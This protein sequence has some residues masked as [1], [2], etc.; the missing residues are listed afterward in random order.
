[1]AAPFYSA[2]SSSS[3]V[4]SSSKSKAPDVA[5]ARRAPSLKAARLSSAPLLAPVFFA[6]G[7][8]TFEF[9]GTNCTTNPKTDFNL[10][11]TI[12][13]KA[14]GVPNLPAGFFPWR[15]TWVDPAGF[16]R[17]ADPASTDDTTTYTYTIPSASTSVIDDKTVDNRGTWRVNLTRPNGSIR[18]IARFVVHEPAAPQA[19]VLVQKYRRD[20]ADQ[21][22]TGENVAFVIQVTNAGP[23][24]ALA[25]HLVD[26]LPLGATLSSFT[27]DSGPTCTAASPGDCT[28]ASMANGDVAEFTAIYNLGSDSPGS[29]STSATAG[30]TTAD[31][32]TS[33][34]SSTAGFDI[35]TGVAN[36]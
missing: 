3:R 22:H 16:V 17:Q 29:Y 28:I 6:E 26:S 31:P 11:D 36:A 27:Q 13:A 8:A 34:N 30:G 18:Q 24:P 12:C 5:S 2:L 1:M 33:N 25:V 9:D 10:G 7:V 20:S 32:D 4:R 14:T 15:I 35:Q 23:D 19:D 21:I